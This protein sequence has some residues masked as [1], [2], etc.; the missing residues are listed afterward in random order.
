MD[1]RDPEQLKKWRPIALLL[2]VASI[3]G[4]LFSLSDRAVRLWNAVYAG[5]EFSGYIIATEGSYTAEGREFLKLL[6]R[7]VGERIVVEAMISFGELS[8]Q[9]ACYERSREWY[10]LARETFGQDFPEPTP[11]G[12]FLT[13]TLIRSTQSCAFSIVEVHEE[14]L[15]VVTRN[16]FGITYRLSGEF[17]VTKPAA[18]LQEHYRLSVAPG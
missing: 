16:P 4:A 15:L 6:Q 17:V 13:I 10:D 14:D 1:W 9:E 11:I 8:A 5:S 18:P 2:L 12:G 7:S 3:V